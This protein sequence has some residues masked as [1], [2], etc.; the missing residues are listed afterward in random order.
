MK[1]II[2]FI[3]SLYDA[4]F[5]V[6]HIKELSILC[7]EVSIRNQIIIDEYEARSAERMSRL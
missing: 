3:K 4:M 6:Q 1:T 7:K 2:K 5:I